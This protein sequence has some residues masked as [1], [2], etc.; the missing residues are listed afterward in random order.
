MRTPAGAFIHRPFAENP[1]VG[2]GFVDDEAPDLGV[3]GP[4]VGAAA[5]ILNRGNFPARRAGDNMPH[6][7]GHERQAIDPGLVNRSPDAA[8]RVLPGQQPLGNANLPNVAAAQDA[9]GLPPIVPDAPPGGGRGERFPWLERLVGID[10]L[11]IGEVPMAELELNLAQ[12]YGE[13]GSIDRRLEGLD[14]IQ[15]VANQVGNTEGEIAAR[16]VALQRLRGGGLGAGALRGQLAASQESALRQ[17][18]EQFAQRGLGGGVPAVAMMQ[19]Q[20]MGAI[21]AAGTEIQDINAVSSSGAIQA[22]VF[23]I[24]DDGG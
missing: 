17:Q 23:A 4:P 20:R 21:G 7:A 8:V 12:R 18:A 6:I 15:V 1:L 22:Q 10:D 13:G 5:D 14:A 3:A 16:E 24:V 9:A 11:R 2:M 19:A